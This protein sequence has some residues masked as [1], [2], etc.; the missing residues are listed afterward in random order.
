[1]TNVFLDKRTKWDIILSTLKKTEELDKKE[2]V[3]GEVE[4]EVKG[5][6][7]IEEQIEGEVGIQTDINE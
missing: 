6:G 5:K 7:E 1:M 3:E 2:Q 4:G